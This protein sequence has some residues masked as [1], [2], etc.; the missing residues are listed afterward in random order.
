MTDLDNVPISSSR[1]TGTKLRFQQFYA[2]IMKKLLYSWRNPF[3]FLS[4]LLLPAF[5]TISAILVDRSNPSPSDSAALDLS[6]HPFKSSQTVFFVNPDEYDLSEQFER[7][8]DSNNKFDLIQ[9][10]SLSN[11]TY[12]A[13]HHLD[14]MSRSDLSHYSLHQPIAAIF[15]NGTAKVNRSRVTSLFNNQAY[16][17][18]AISLRYVDN[19]IIR[20]RLKRSDFKLDVI[21]HP[22]PRTADEKLTSAQY[23]GQSQFQLSQSIMFAMSFLSASFAVLLVKERSIK[24]KHLQMVC[25][26]KLYIF[27]ITSFIVDFLTYIIPCFLIM[28]M[29]KLFNE[30]HLSPSDQEARILLIFVIHGFAMLPFVYFLS[31]LFDVPSTAYVRI[32]LYNVILGIG[33]FLAVVITELPTLK[34]QSVSKGLNMVFSLF[35]PNYSLGRSIY[36][37]YNNHIGNNICNSP[38]QM[39]MPFDMNGTSH[40]GDKCHQIPG[41]GWVCEVTLSSLCQFVDNQDIPPQQRNRF[42]AIR[43]CCKGNVTLIT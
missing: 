38:Q 10:I 26:V 33:S 11:L 32:C 36:N 16:H 34:I 39:P 25:G 31:F 6:L 1:N 24:G 8:G 7:L 35:L 14:S 9:N 3:L 29:Y 22:M 15:D 17:S 19:A 28:L 18:P 20:H 40:M 4:Q 13:I 43:M 2:L 37:L 42:D 12:S 30:T 5:F 27:W 23:E 41:K 21:N